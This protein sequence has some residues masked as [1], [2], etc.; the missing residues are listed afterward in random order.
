MV[1]AKIDLFA[2]AVGFGFF[3]DAA[4]IRSAAQEAA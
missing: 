4:T 3:A 1:T 2:A